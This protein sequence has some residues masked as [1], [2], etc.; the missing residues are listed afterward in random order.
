MT[1]ISVTAL[2]P[3]K[4]HSERLPNKNIKIFHGKPLY[5]VVLDTLIKSRYINE[6]IINT[7]I[8]SIL[9]LTDINKK[10][11][12]IERPE[13]L[14]G[15]FVPFFDIIEFDMSQTKNNI[16]LHTHCTNPILRTKTID[17]AILTFAN[18]DSN[19][20][21]LGVNRLNKRAYSSDKRPLNHD[22]HDKLL[23]TQDLS[24]IYV[25]NS[26]MYIFTRE[27]FQNAGNHRIGHTPYFYEMDEIESIDIDFEKDFYFAETIYKEFKD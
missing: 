13:N 2:M 1:D 3:M 25:D 9:S 12:L 10:V 4:A 8:D 23:R 22:P 6:I 17:N 26:C 11:R 16:F 27:S 15:D 24:P 19:D 14:R 5:K 7:D 20:S 18:N 21:L